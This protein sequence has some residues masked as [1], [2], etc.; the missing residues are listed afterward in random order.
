MAGPE[1]RAYLRA[2]LAG[3][4]AALEAD[5]PQEML[6]LSEELATVAAPI[7]DRIRVRALGESAL[8]LRLLGK[9]QEA[10]ARL[11]QAWEETRR[12][13]LPQ[14]T[15]A[16][17]ATY[18]VVLRPS[19]DWRRRRRSWRSAWRWDSDWRNSVLREPTTS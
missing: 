11:R 8:A 1:R 9:N 2:L 6:T 13:V 3:T 19:A 14:G 18:A 16:I 7:D 15:L 10:E 5:D 4:G 12:L 17:G